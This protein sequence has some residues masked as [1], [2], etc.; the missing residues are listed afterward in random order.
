MLCER[1]Q[2]GTQAAAGNGDDEEIRRRDGAVEI[3]IEMQC[4]RQRAA[5]Q[6][7]GVDLRFAHDGW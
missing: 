4:L 7:A 6:V 1:G 3:R 5:G 2:R